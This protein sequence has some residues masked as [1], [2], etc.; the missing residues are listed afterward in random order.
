MQ[1]ASASTRTLRAD[2]HVVLAILERL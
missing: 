2:L 1:H